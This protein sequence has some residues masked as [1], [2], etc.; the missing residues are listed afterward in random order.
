MRKTPNRVGY[1]RF[2]K[3]RGF[4]HQ[5]YILMVRLCGGSFD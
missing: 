3:L 5:S 1:P 2:W 4:L